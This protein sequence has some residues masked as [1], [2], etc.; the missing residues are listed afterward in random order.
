MADPQ[1][2]LQVSEKEKQG[3]LQ[4]LFAKFTAVIGTANIIILVIAFVFFN[5][6]IK[7]ATVNL[8]KANEDALK[9][10]GKVEA[11]K[12]MVSA[13]NIA[14]DSSLTSM[15]NAIAAKNKE[16]TKA[17]LSVD[18]ILGQ[19]ARDKLNDLAMIL[20]NNKKSID[21]LLK[22]NLTSPRIIA[23]GRYATM[24]RGPKEIT[25]S[26]S[27]STIT[28]LIGN[29]V[30]GIDFVEYVVYEASAN[31]AGYVVHLANKDI[32]DPFIFVQ[33]NGLVPHVDYIDKENV[34]VLKFADGKGN[35]ITNVTFSLF[36]IGVQ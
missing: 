28:E 35:F 1:I 22:L 21:E 27:K 20:G 25:R 7:E 36:V 10:Q 16:V 14:V 33:A 31:N 24:N 13:K 29:N 23:T 9:V 11:I 8:S 26:G 6:K 15:E 5:D 18:T 19:G 30:S 2:V 32:K 34:Y 17:L 4:S 12:E 3:K